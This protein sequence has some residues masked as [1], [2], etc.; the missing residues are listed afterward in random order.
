MDKSEIDDKILEQIKKLEE[1]YEVMGQ[2]LS[3]YLDGLLYSDYLTYWDYVHLDTLLSLQTPKTRMKDEMIF[4]VY[5]QFTELYF[6]L[7][8]WEMEQV[9]TADPLLSADEFIEKLR[10]INRYF[11]I[12]EKSF[13]VMIFGMDRPQFL[14]FRMSLLPSSGFQS[15]Q[16]RFIEFHATDVYNLLSHSARR[17]TAE[18]EPIEELMTKLYWKEGST[19]L[20]SGKK[21]LTLRQFEEKYMDRFIAEGNRLKSSNFLQLYRKHYKADERA[22][23][24]VEEM[25]KFDLFA[26]V[27]WPLAHYKSAVKYLH[28][29][30]E[31]IAA[32][33]GTNW[34]RYLPPR[35]QKIIFFP[36][37][38]S[39]EEQENWGKKWV[40]NQLASGKK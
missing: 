27:L 22:P 3:S 13:D 1:K 32:T 16:Y 9:T 29:D 8:L 37:L 26:N 34:Q 18:D 24:I 28:K 17:E 33:G 7:V 36:E 2:D 25:K 4:I 20:A 5:H 11:E 35:F 14:K 6:K 19:E 30:P 39:T 23:E 38:W 31:D 10:R 21:T 40:L 12:L 15:A